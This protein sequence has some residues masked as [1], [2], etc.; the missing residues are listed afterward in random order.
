MM[1]NCSNSRQVGIHSIRIEKFN[2]H[3]F[4]SDHDRKLITT[5]GN[6][7]IIDELEIYSDSGSGCDSFLFDFGSKYIIIDCN[8][9]WFSIDKNTGALKNEGWKWDEKLPDNPLGKFQATED[10]SNYIY[11]PGTNF[12]KSD[13]YKYKDP[14]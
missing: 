3:P 14:K 4:L 5:D 12:S 10:V 8:G 11:S 1:T 7:R 9:Q 13:V 2:Q 6:Q